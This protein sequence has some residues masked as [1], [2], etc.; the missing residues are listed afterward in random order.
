VAAASGQK[1]Q[2]VTTKMGG[3]Q[4]KYLSG[5]LESSFAMEEKE[6]EQFTGELTTL[7]SKIWAI[8]NKGN[9]DPQTK[10]KMIGKNHMTGD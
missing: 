1:Q 9:P 5:R 7:E 4:Q 2:C 8:S 3:S 6:K 10:N